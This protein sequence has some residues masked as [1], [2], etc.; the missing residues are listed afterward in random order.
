MTLYSK[1]MRT[2]L[3][4]TTSTFLP[5]ALSNFRSF[6]TWQRPCSRAAKMRIRR[7]SKKMSA[8]WNGQRI[9]KG[10]ACCNSFAASFCCLQMNRA[11]ILRSIITALLPQTGL[12]LDRSAG[13]SWTW[14]WPIILV[15]S[16]RIATG[17]VVTCLISSSRAN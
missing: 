2:V 9:A 8:G 11:S 15:M 12:S 3:E 16:W 17:K 14:A 1:A 6:M 10:Q 4:L 13:E 7:C 5:R